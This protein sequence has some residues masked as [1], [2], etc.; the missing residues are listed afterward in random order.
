MKG[1]GLESHL[2]LAW[3]LDRPYSSQRA[4]RLGWVL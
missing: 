1:E 3:G 4:S 2:L